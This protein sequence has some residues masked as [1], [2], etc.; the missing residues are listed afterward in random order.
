MPSAVLAGRLKEA[1]TRSVDPMDSSVIG[2]HEMIGMHAMLF[3]ALTGLICSHHRCYDC[4]WVEAYY[5]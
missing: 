3:R 2:L 4:Q 1:H 5:A